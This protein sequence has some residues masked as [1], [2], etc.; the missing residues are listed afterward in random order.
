MRRAASPSGSTRPG[1]RRRASRTPRVV[2]SE[3]VIRIMSVPAM[4][5]LTASVLSVRPRAWAVPSRESVMVTPG[6]P[7]L[8]AQQ[9]HR[10]RVRPARRVA[11]S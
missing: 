2:F 8:A 10:D 11:G 6:E 7:E 3:P 1:R 4:A 5:A 9:R